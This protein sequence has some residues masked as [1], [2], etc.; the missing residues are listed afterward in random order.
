MKKNVGS[1]DRVIRVVVG[2]LL[3]GLA[4]TGAVPALAAGL[5]MALA[6]LVGL[7]LI[8]TA[9]VNF[10]PMYRLLGINTCRV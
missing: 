3:I 1:V 4:L 5:G 9:T 10:C 7:V 2:V 6:I 8:G